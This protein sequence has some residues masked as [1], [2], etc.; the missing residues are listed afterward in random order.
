MMNALEC[1]VF[2]YG[3]TQFLFRAAEP[4][5][6]MVQQ[7]VYTRCYAPLDSGFRC[8]LRRIADALRFGQRRA[9][10]RLQTQPE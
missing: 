7:R 4:H 8:L 2:L 9:G 3:L 5:A 6:R 10:A 1:R